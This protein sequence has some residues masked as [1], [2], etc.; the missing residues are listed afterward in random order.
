MKLKSFAVFVAIGF[1]IAFVSTVVYLI[2]SERDR[3]KKNEEDDY[4]RETLN[5]PFLQDAKT[6]EFIMNSKT[7]FIMRGLPGSG[8]SEIARNMKQVYGDLAV[9]C[10]ADDLRLN[11]QGEY[12]WKMEEYEETHSKCNKKASRTC[13]D[14][15]P[16]VVID[17]TNVDS[18]KLSKYI[19]IAHN[20]GYHVVLVEP[21]TWWK[22]NITELVLRNQHSVN[23]DTLRDQMSKFKQFFAVY[24]GWFPSEEKL[25]TLKDYMLQ[26]LRDCIE[27]IPSFRDQLTKEKYEDAQDFSTTLTEV[28]CAALS[29]SCLEKQPYR[30]HITSYFDQGIFG[31]K[32]SDYVS[33]S[34]VQEALGSVTTLT[35]IAWTI[36]PRALTARVKLSPS[37]LKLWRNLDSGASGEEGHNFRFKE[38]AACVSDTETSAFIP[39]SYANLAIKPTV[40]VGDTA[41][42]TLSLQRDTRPIQ[43]RHDMCELIR[44]EMANQGY[45][46]Y[47]VTK[48]LARDYGDGHWAVYLNEP[49]YIDALFTGF[50]GS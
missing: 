48:G 47:A 12:I 22:Y 4:D 23:E 45:L 1:S 8:K 17:N 5:F 13:E 20:T 27:K 9:I 33:L 24:Y 30:L 10:S 46:E 38:A 34:A 7:M 42:I 41:H 11:E 43:G 25:R 32:S 44:L 37:Q 18:R 40:G 14:G 28:T 50:Y 6:I 19:T 3:R 39:V 31:H 2:S 29:L 36:T 21:R 26:I 35:V 16:V 15:I 49:I